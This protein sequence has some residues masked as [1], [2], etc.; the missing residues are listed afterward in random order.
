MHIINVWIGMPDWLNGGGG[1]PYHYKQTIC[2]Y[3]FKLS[4]LKIVIFLFCSYNNEL[5]ELFLNFPHTDMN[6]I[7]R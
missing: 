1:E 4:I 6:L 3:Y 5:F 2:L 7:K